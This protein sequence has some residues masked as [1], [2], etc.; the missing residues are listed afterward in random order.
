METVLTYDEFIATNVDQDPAT[1]AD[2]FPKAQV[3]GHKVSTDHLL[4]IVD[5]GASGSDRY[6]V[7][8]RDNQLDRCFADLNEAQEYL[9]WLTS[10]YADLY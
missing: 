3:Y 10:T 4:L 5:T 1:K 9:Y 6:V 2:H 8:D 7:Y